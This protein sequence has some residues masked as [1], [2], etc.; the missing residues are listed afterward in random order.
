MSGRTVS[1]WVYPKKKGCL[2]YNDK[3]PL[4]GK[5]KSIIFAILSER[6]RLFFESRFLLSSVG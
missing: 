4:E 2:V 6:K 3:N 1:M 5:I